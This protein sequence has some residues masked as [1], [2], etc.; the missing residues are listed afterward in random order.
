MTQQSQRWNVQDAYAFCGNITRRAA[1]NFYVAFLLLPR[2]K[3]QA[4]Y[5]AYAFARRV[6]DIADGV[7][8]NPRKSRQLEQ[9]R[10]DVVAASNGLTPAS[11]P[12]NIA[13]SDAIRRHDIPPEHLLGLVDGMEMDLTVSRYGNFLDL[14]RYCYLAASLVGLVCIEIFGY[15]GDDEARARAIDLGIA[16]QLT[17]ILRDVEEDAARNRI[18]LPADELARFGVT[19]EQ[20]RSGQS[21]PAFRDLMAFQAERARDYFARGRELL[22]MLHPAGRTCVSVLGGV[23]SLLLDRIEERDYDVFGTRVRVPN[24]TKIRLATRAWLGTA[25]AW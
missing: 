9:C 8:S 18:Y 21:D 17:N 4:I 14:R 11:D 7:A 12:I 23:Y 24:R 15:Q 16:M 5:A 22:P 19:E 6:D 13:L 3:R 2:E 1:R 25:P 20:I 10:Q